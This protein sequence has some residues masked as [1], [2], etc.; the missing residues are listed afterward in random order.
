MSYYV[1]ILHA[2]NYNRYYIGQTQDVVARL[3][4]HNNRYEF[5]TAPYVPWRLVCFIE[6]AT[7]SEA[8]LLERKLKHLNRM[9]LER[10][11]I[12]YGNR[13]N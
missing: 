4:R 8:L 7:R 11:I 3:T 9:K 12:K 10:F 6:K 2:E 5:A 1:Y 13:G